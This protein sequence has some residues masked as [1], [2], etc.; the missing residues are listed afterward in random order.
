MAGRGATLTQAAA[1]LDGGCAT[2]DATGL[3]ALSPAV[4]LGA[5]WTVAAW[6][7]DVLPDGVHGATA[8]FAATAG[9]AALALSVDGFL[10]MQLADTATFY[11]TAPRRGADGLAGWHHIAAVGSGGSTAVYVDGVLAGSAPR[12]AVGSVACVG[13]AGGTTPRAAAAI[14][15]VHVFHRALNSS[16]VAAIVA[17]YF[18][19]CRTSLAVNVTASSHAAA[20]VDLAWTVHGHAALPALRHAVRYRPAL[21]GA[22]AT[23][24]A[25]KLRPVVSAQAAAARVQ[26]V[27]ALLLP[28]RQVADV[29]GAS[30]TTRIALCPEFPCAAWPP[31]TPCVCAGEPY[32]YQ[33]VTHGPGGV[34]VASTSI[35]AVLTPA[36]PALANVTLA[37][38][39]ECITL[40]WT[41][42][43][44]EG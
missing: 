15:D 44:I 14:D 10:G 38:D 21:A 12:Q 39:S 6:A 24:A 8:V 42:P 9:D 27:H 35:Q 1:C 13:S 3:I 4:V 37:I 2:L 5:E 36:L 22:A 40:A 31:R 17:A 30:N 20:G 18:G 34:A 19:D 16:E 7:R 43:A 29:P 26:S 32:D 33:V 28:W 11:G 41:P 23:L 25:N